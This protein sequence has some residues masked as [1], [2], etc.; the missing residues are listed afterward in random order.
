[1]KSKQFLLLIFFC[2]FIVCILSAEGVKIPQPV[3][4]VNDFAGILQEDV[5]NKIN[6]WA[7]ELREKGGVD[8]TIATFKEIGTTDE[9]AFGVKLYETWK[10]GSKRDEGVLV[11]LAVKERKLRIE[12]EIGRASCRER[13]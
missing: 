4:F 5:R 1:M 10:I 12:V 13:V 3:G 9:V 6:D 11:L 8:F 2:L 7:I